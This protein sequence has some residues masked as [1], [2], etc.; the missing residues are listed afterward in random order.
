MNQSNQSE[1]IEKKYELWLH[2]LGHLVVGF[3]NIGGWDLKGDS[4][5]FTATELGSE[6]IF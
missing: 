1:I 2:I 6:R 3:T 4:R 5:C